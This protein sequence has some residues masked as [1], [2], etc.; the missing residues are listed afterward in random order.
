METNNH[1]HSHSHVYWQFRI[2]HSLNLHVFGLQ[3]D[4]RAHGGNPLTH[5][6][7]TDNEKKKPDQ[8]TEPMSFLL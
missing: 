6:E 3:E 1:V 5:G 2:T 7:H 4:T 8:G